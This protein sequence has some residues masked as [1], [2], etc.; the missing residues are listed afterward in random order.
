MIFEQYCSM[1]QEAPV[2][3]VSDP[4]LMQIGSIFI[5]KDGKYWRM[6]SHPDPSATDPTAIGAQPVTGPYSD[7]P[8]TA[9]PTYISSNL[10]QQGSWKSPRELTTTDASGATGQKKPEDET[11]WY[12]K[13]VTWATDQLKQGAGRY[14]D[15]IGQWATGKVHDAATALFKKPE[16][17]GE[18]VFGYRNKPERGALSN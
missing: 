16:K 13:P 17:R 5:H 1:L 15:P 9:P 14:T 6:T 18:G 7:A 4:T 12:G 2:L 11:A 8:A 10:I 3:P